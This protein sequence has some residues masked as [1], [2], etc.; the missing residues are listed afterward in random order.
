MK[1][2]LTLKAYVTPALRAVRLAA[3]YQ[4]LLSQLS[5]Y[6]DNPIFT[7]PEPADG[8]EGND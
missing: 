4:F 2:I 3:E 1:S 5:D 7:D 8:N 6:V